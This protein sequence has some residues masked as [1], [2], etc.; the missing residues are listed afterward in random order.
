VEAPLRRRRA[1]PAFLAAAAL[2]ALVVTA[3]APF[4]DETRGGEREALRLKTAERDLVELG[5][6]L[7]FDPGLSSEG[8][9]SCASCHDPEHGFGDPERRSTD[10]LGGTRRH[11]QAL[12]D[13]RVEG[14][15]HSDGEFESFAD[16]VAFRITGEAPSGSA[17]GGY[18]AAMRRLL[19]RSDTPLH[20]DDI[21]TTAETD[22]GRG[23][24]PMLGRPASLVVQERDGA[25][26]L[27]TGKRYEQALRK[28]GGSGRLDVPLATRAL[29]AYAGTLRSGRSA[30]D[31]HRSGDRAAMS[32]SA[33]RG[34]EV[35]LGQGRCVQ[36]HA[37]NEEDGWIPFRDGKYHN[38]GVAWLQRKGDDRLRRF[39]EGVGG[40][41]LVLE[42]DDSPSELGRSG[43][44]N[45]SSD[46]RAFKTPTLRDVARHPPYFHDGSH[47]TLEAVV[48]HYAGGGGTDP[49][50]DERVRGIRLDPGQVRD[51]VAF[52]EAL[53][54]DE[55]PGVADVRWR[56]RAQRTR[57]KFVDA[58]DRPMEGLEVLPVPAGDVVPGA[59]DVDLPERLT[60]DAKGE[61]A[62]A[63]PA[64]THVRLRLPLD[65][66]PLGGDLVPDTCQE[67]V[68]RLPVRGRVRVVFELRD[69]VLEA[70]DVLRAYERTGERQGISA[71]TRSDRVLPVLVEPWPLHR[72]GLTQAG[73]TRVA[74][75]EAW[76]YA[77]AESEP[78]LVRLPGQ[79]APMTIRLALHETPR[80]T[81]TAQGGP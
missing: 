10:D 61:I 12:I 17:P 1:R 3:G 65:L 20:P 62:Y 13:V 2:G 11:S 70:P 50:R 29:K 30:Y 31:S 25:A 26:R 35:F 55:R 21:P 63:V 74:L 77:H 80:L 76:M 38:T 49:E 47:A 59:K 36:C 73:T 79:T 39:L 57:L 42:F 44:T 41:Q 46:I 27:R 8:R 40:R 51:V 56:A 58:D 64:R 53:S 14:E 19:L 75:Y 15:Q 69:A 22:L 72:V 81:A 33:R 66:V 4:A 37:V 9:F 52:L 5:R 24:F 7:F 6:R 34:L 60:T 48:R 43:V 67:A 45:N 28:M 54:S 71:P 23:V 18:E 68:V 32:E 78:L 16:L